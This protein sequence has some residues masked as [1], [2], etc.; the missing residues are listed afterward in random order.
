MIDILIVG[1]GG[2]GLSVALSAKKQG[3]KV[4]LVGKKYTTTS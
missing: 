2:A 1:T 3:K 4:L